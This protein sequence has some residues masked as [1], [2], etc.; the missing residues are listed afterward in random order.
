MLAL[1]LKVKTRES[2]VNNP[3]AIHIHSHCIIL[4]AA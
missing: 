3:A 2:I 4:D 1:P